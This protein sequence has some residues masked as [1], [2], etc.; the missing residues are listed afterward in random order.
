MTIKKAYV[1]LVEFLELNKNKKVSTILDELKGMCESKSGGSDVGKTFLK[2]EDGK[3]IAIYCYYHKVW[4][5]LS[6]VEYGV[7]TNTASGFN[8][9]CKAGVSSW[10]KQQRVATKSKAELLTKLG[11]GEIEVTELSDLQE[12][13]ETERVKIVE[14]DNIHFHS[15]ELLKVWLAE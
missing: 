2:D 10:T 14:S 13:I 8:T 5:P 15:Q 1:E 3:V 4:E 12:Q 7:K 11:S 9:M 6:E